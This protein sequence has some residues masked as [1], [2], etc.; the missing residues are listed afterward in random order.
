MSVSRIGSQIEA[1]SWMVASGFQVALS[2]F[3]G[4]NLGAGQIKR[5]G[6]GY[7]MSMRLLVPYGLA[8]NALLFFFAE[9]LFALFINDPGTT[10][11]G[12]EYLRIISI[13]QIFMIIELTTAGAFNGLGKTVIPSTIGMIG[14]ALR[15]PFA[16]GAG[17]MAAIWWTISLSSVFKGTIM[18]LIFVI[19]FYLRK[20]NHPKVRMVENY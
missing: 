8:I 3:V 20:Q 5:I 11:Y 10:P 16:L 12:A 7:K 4:Q 18:V 17:S 15:I 6:L 19:Y 2:A 9:P 14:N 13:S 1:L